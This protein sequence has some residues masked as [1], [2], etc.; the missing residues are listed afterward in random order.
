MPPTPAANFINSSA[1]LKDADNT[2]D[3]ALQAEKDRALAAESAID[4]RLT[5]IEGQA[6]GNIG[7]LST[8]NT[9]TKDTLVNAVNEVHDDVVAEK[10]RAEGV[11]ATLDSDIQAEAAARAAQD[12]VIEASLGL[13]ADGSFDGNGLN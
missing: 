5:N 12:D 3:T 4:S 9:D 11:E 7:D 1:S 8:L 2:L 10:T 13:E 6:G